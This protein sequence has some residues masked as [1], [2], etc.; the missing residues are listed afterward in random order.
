MI[1][2]RP[3]MTIAHV[4]ALLLV[5]WNLSAATSLEF[6]GTRVGEIAAAYFQ[7]FNSDGLD[8]PREFEQTYR[9]AEALEQ[10]TIEERM[11]L[12]EQIRGMLGGL[13][14]RVITE[15]AETSLVVAA[16]SD[17]AQSWFSVRFLLED[18]GAGAG[19]LASLEIQ[20]TGDPNRELTDFSG[21]SS[22]EELVEWVRKDLDSPAV[23]VAVANHSGILHAAAS[24]VRMLGGSDAA[25]P[26]D[27][28]H[29]GSVTKSM[30]A[31]M[32]AA[33]IESGKLRW[34]TKLSA[35]LPNMEMLDVYRNVTIEQLLHHRAGIQPYLNFDESELTRWLSIDG[36]PTEQRAAFLAHVLSQDPVAAPGTSMNY[37]NA[38]YAL[39]GYVAE[40]ATGR[41]WEALVQDHLFD[42]LR[43]STAGIG[44]PATEEQP[45]AVHG[46]YRFGQ[47]VALQE[48]GT[49]E[50]GAFLAPAGDIHMSASDLARYGQFHLAG[51]SGADGML[52]G[53]TVAR[54][55]QA[56]T[57]GEGAGPGY[58]CGWVDGETEFGRSYQW[59]NGSAGTFHALLALFPNEG[60][61]IAA[62]TNAGGPESDQVFMRMNEAILEK[63]GSR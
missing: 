13:D 7:A 6:P 63:L 26:D 31:T 53:A 32:V 12:Y 21:W 34:E 54:L 17:Q 3:M 24:G 4:T 14:P 23:S 5:S 58:A 39:A 40:V 29:V 28:F 16:F 18:K 61:V 56:P 41:S 52:K 11:G 62:L 35:A 46:H 48:P 1:R 9:S 51:M 57:D 2:L 15:V 8:G 36:T 60:V 45:A 37:S 25:L 10:R 59:H 43:L 47:E 55:H 22:M 49:Y 30:T 42:A 19:K 33:V 50:L 27:A 38:G 44:W 20:P